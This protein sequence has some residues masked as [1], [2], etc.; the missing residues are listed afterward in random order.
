MYNQWQQNLYQSQSSMYDDDPGILSEVET[1]STGFRRGA[2]IR[3]SLPIVRTP[4]KSL[5][6]P[7][8]MF[9]AR[10]FQ[11]LGPLGPLI[12]S[13]PLWSP[14][15]KCRY[16]IYHHLLEMFLHLCYCRS[17]VP[18][19]QKRNQTCIVAK[20]SDVV[21]HGQ[22]PVRQIILQAAV[23]GVPRLYP[24]SHLHPRSI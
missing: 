23:H 14:R 6:R 19:V 13:P 9:V 24:S 1:A 18:T 15:F 8:G 3:S 11:S 21:G 22:S 2:K 7:L 17:C 5:E 12:S 10:H 16:I 4:S 20:R